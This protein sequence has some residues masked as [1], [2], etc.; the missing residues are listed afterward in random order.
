MKVIGPLVANH[1]V[2]VGCKLYLGKNVNFNGGS[3]EGSGEVH[4][5]NN[6][7]SGSNLRAMTTNHD[8][9]SDILPYAE[10]II[11]NKNI[12]IGDNVWIGDN[13]T[14]LPGVNIGEGAVIQY[15][16]V[17]TGNIPALSIA[18][19]H[20]AKVFSQRDPN[21]YYKTKKAMAINNEF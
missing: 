4:I 15:G 11:I 2:R 12:K 9:H 6:F 17:V 21:H 10:N 16:S 3:F 20:P 5:G 1:K 8:I 7:Y 18:G 14:L 13:V 19:G